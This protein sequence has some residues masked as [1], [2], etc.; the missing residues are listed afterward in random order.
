QFR[1]SLDGTDVPVAEPDDVPLLRAY[2]S[3]LRAVRAGDARAVAIHDEPDLEVHDVCLPSNGERIGVL[4]LSRVP[5]VPRSEIDGGLAEDAARGS[6][7]PF[8]GLAHHVALLREPELVVQYAEGEALESVVT[9]WVGVFKPSSSL[10]RA[11]A[12]AEPP[13]HDS[14]HANLVRD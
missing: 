8:E 3:A 4:A 7:A 14:W 2:A 5:V 1:V 11:F 13:T 6:A 9:E 12:D 10:D